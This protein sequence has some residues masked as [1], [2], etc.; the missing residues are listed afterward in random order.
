MKT[1]KE[2]A[3]ANK[4]RYKIYIEHQVDGEYVSRLG[5]YY[6]RGRTP[7]LSLYALLDRVLVTDLDGNKIA[8]NICNV[9]GG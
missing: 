2:K 1:N 3:K 7:M 6:S 9:R 4:N 5:N 8:R